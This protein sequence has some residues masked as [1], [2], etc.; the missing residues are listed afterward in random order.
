MA[1]I[2]WAQVALRFAA[3]LVVVLLPPLSLYLDHHVLDSSLRPNYVF[4]GVILFGL[5]GLII[6]IWAMAESLKFG[7]RRGLLWGLAIG[8]SML[9]S[10]NSRH[11]PDAIDSLRIAATYS[12][13]QK[14]VTELRERFKVNEATPLMIIWGESGFAGGTYS[15]YLTH[16]KDLEPFKAALSDVKGTYVSATADYSY[17]IPMSRQCLRKVRHI[18]GEFYLI[19]AT[20]PC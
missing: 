8:A 3:P 6:F 1:S 12:K 19:E 5:S 13:L 2:T 11:L 9:V 4:A 7:I 18:S 15:T 20:L 17:G 16:S 10:L 14:E